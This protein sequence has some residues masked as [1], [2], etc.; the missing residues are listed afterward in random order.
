MVKDWKANTRSIGKPMNLKR[1][2]CGDL[3]LLWKISK[4]QGDKKEM[5]RVEKIYIKK[6]CIG[7]K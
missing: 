7:K 4:E 3:A 6:K 1:K 2:S 5:Q